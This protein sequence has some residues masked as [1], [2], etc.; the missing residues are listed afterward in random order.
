MGYIISFA[1]LMGVSSPDFETCLTNRTCAEE[2]V[3]GY[4][5]KYG[6]DCDASA[7]VDCYDYARIHKLGFGQCSGDAIL[8]TDYWEKFEI[9]YGGDN[10]PYDPPINPVQP[11]AE[12]YDYG[13]AN[14]NARN[15]GY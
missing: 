7:Y 9:C 13:D 1:V 11:P 5:R 15:A 14:I 8:S 4:M 6:Q 3:R 2:A 12:E 10:Q